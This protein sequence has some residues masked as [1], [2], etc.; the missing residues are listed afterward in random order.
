MPASPDPHHDN[1]MMPAC[2]TYPISGGLYTAFGLTRAALGRFGLFDENIYPAFFEDI[3]FQVR[4]TRM[5]PP[6]EVQVLP[7]VI[8]QRGKQI[9][10]SY[11]SGVHMDDLKREQQGRSFWQR[12]AHINKAYV[13]R[14]WGCQGRDFGG[15]RYKTPFNKSLPTW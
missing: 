10:Q 12:R 6:M 14:K 1:L 5:Q 8:M 13:L 11:N 3:D 2:R 4:Q 9:D 7:D 15:C